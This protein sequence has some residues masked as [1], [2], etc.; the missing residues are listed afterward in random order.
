MAGECK[1]PDGAWSLMYGQK[2]DIEG[3]LRHA[4]AQKLKREAKI[5][6]AEE[7]LA[8]PEAKPSAKIYA[9]ADIA[10]ALADVPTWEMNLQAAHIELAAIVN[11]MDKLEPM[12]KYAHLPVL[13]ATEACQQ[14]EWCLELQGRAENYIASQGFIPADHISTMRS[15]PEFLTRILPHIQAIS[16]KMNSAP[17]IPFES[18]KF[19]GPVD[20]A[21]LPESKPKPSI[22]LVSPK[23]E[24]AKPT[25]KSRIGSGAILKGEE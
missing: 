22:M 4:E 2:I 3:K 21:V 23:Q 17:K 6:A 25:R 24:Q 8:D 15:H 1:T 14:E 12:R 20:V 19:L 10:E 9:Q 13:E 5:M 11:I 18:M 7:V 16:V